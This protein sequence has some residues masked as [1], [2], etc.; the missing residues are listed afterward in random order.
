MTIFGKASAE[1]TARYRQRFAHVSSRNLGQTSLQISQAGFG[2][3]RI[4]HGQGWHEQALRF[5]LQQGINLIDTSSNYTDGNSER[6]IGRVLTELIDSGEL[7]RD[8]LVLISKVGYVQ[9]FNYTLAEQRKKAGR[10]FANIVKFSE[11]LD[12]CI[13][14]EFIADQLD[15]SLERLG[16][17]TLDGYLLHNPEYYLK[18]AKQAHL[19]REEAH[20]VYYQRIQLAFEQLEEEVDN[21]RIQY[22][23]VSA[24]TFADP[25]G[26]FTFTSLAKL[27]QIANDVRPNH[28]FRLVQLPFN[29]FETGA[30]T[31]PNQP[32]QQTVLQWAAE[33][34]LALLANRP[35]NAFYGDNLIRLAQVDMPLYPATAEDVSTA[36]DTLVQLEQHFQQQLLGTLTVSA[37]EKQILHD[38]LAVGQ[39]LDGRWQ[40]FGSYQNWL[41]ICNQF[42][43]PRAQSAAEFLSNRANLAADGIN[44]LDD[45]VEAANIMLAA[46]KA[47]YQEMAAK[48]CQ[49]IQTA[50]AEADADWATPTLSQT[51]V[52]ALRSTTG[53]TAVLVGMRQQ[54]YVQDVLA[55]LAHP[56]AQKPR[57]DSWHK[58]QEAINQYSA[59]NPSK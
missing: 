43:L 29:L 30:A 10:P 47:Y 5:A 34:Q 27:W 46:M 19:G 33:Q 25:A 40:G 39:M 48:Q 2:G 54:A 1:G 49:A 35:L 52:R 58:L 32:N 36:V 7:Q 59:A 41:D 42:I 20:E 6:L 12:H 53:V 22:Y 28:H 26:H 21:G 11:G 23:G 56:V 13:H 45:Y 24:N 3:Y 8:E 18:W 17:A 51:A 44:W 57:A 38:Y 37:E 31:E 16:V 4:E 9:G 15:R 50:V 55:E 14:P